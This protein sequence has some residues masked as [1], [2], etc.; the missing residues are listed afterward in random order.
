ME[1][2]GGRNGGSMRK[3]RRKEGEHGKDE[4]EEGRG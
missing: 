3:E 1:I 4:K 2:K